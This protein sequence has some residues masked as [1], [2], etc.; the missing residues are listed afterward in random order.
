M[1]QVDLGRP[2]TPRQYLRLFL[3]GFAMGSA[4]IVPGVS[5]GTMAFILGIYET[6]I[7]AIKS[8][9]VKAIRL[10]ISLKLRDLFEHVPFG[11]LIAVGMG[12]LT[13][14]F[15]LS[16]LLHDALEYYPTYVFAFFGGLV[17]ASIIAVGAKLRY[18]PAVIAVLVLFSVVA[19]VVVGLQEVQTTDHSPLTLFI[20]GAIAI[21]AMIL[22]GISGSFILLI[23]GQY[24]H[25]LGSVRALDI[26]S[27]GA[28]ALGALVG[29]V[30]F[31]RV[32]SFLL[33]HYEQLTIAALTGFMIGSLRT[34]W[35]RSAAGTETL[36]QFG[37]A[38][39]ALA[40]GLLLLGFLIVSF[41]DHL[42]S[43]KNPIFALFWRPR[44]A[45]VNPANGN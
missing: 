42:Q 41:L 21:C 12:I 5:G 22:P 26:V 13:A 30:G 32:L 43:G 29:I 31:S 7:G 14:I 10:A 23:L 45:P 40:V 25:V 19:F 33:K 24:H 9:N 1:N 15:A 34:V 37:A 35:D 3:T 17:L 28:V 16:S 8:F 38:E 4:D 27:L 11:F 44:T 6:L 18:T 39:L 36:P 2:R 20:S